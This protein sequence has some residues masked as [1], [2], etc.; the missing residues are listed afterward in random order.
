MSE[1]RPSCHYYEHLP[2]AKPRECPV[3]GPPLKRA[4]KAR[5]FLRREFEPQTFRPDGPLYPRTF[6][7]LM[8]H[9]R[10]ILDE[11]ISKI[12]VNPEFEK[13]V[14]E[15]LRWLRAY[16]QYTM[17]NPTWKQL[18]LRVVG[19]DPRYQVYYQLGCD[20]REILVV[21]KDATCG[22]C[23]QSVRYGLPAPLDRR[24]D[25]KRQPYRY[26]NGRGEGSEKQPEGRADQSDQGIAHR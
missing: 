11:E 26:A 25:P 24:Q 15:S 23:A 21:S 13:G 16:S 12:T 8:L 4:R 18:P 6:C 2:C 14:D 17:D 22:Q 9:P 7:G 3:H 20:R 5:H 10:L 19:D 1:K